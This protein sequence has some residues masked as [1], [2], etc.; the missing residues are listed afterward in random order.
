MRKRNFKI[1]YEFDEFRPKCIAD[2]TELVP[3]FREGRRVL[4]RCPVCK[5]TNEMKRRSYFNIL[6]KTKIPKK[7]EKQEPELSKPP[8][9][10][11]EGGVVV[12]HGSIMSEA[13]YLKQ[14]TR[15]E[16]Q[17]LTDETGKKFLKKYKVGHEQTAQEHVP[18]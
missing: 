8:Y 12:P 17:V 2:G 13:E 11:C 15:G 5:K 14:K 6:D 18:C 9:D 1:I 7:I 3:H 16:T 10:V 4:L